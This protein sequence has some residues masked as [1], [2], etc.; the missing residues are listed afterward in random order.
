MV[1]FFLSHVLLA[2]VDVRIFLIPFI[3][4][5][6]LLHL[7]YTDGSISRT[8]K[9]GHHEVVDKKGNMEVDDL[10]DDQKSFCEEMDVTNADGTIVHVK[11]WHHHG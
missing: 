9:D 10:A 5:S 3:F 7:K 4:N 6:P 1:V 2:V 8:L 11:K